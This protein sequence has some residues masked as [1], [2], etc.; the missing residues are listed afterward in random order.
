[1]QFL[2]NNI[3]QCIHMTNPEN[4]EILDRQKSLGPGYAR[5]KCLQNTPDIYFSKFKMGNLH[6]CS[7]FLEGQEELKITYPFS[8]MT[9]LENTL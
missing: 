5:A 4:L 9:G 1:M 3:D 8:Y 2:R 7:M 6:R